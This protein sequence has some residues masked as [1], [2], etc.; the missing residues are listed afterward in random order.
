M[1]EN[2]VKVKNKAKITIVVLIAFLLLGAAS[3]TILFMLKGVGNPANGEVVI[4]YSE[5][6]KATDQATLQKLLAHESNM[7][8]EVTDDIMIN[9]P[10]TVKGGKKLTGDGTISMALYVKPYQYM[11][12]VDQDSKLELDG[13]TIDGNGSSN[14]VKV[15][16][17]AQCSLLS[18][19]LTYGCPTVI[20]SFGD[21]YIK[22]GAIVDAIGTGVY[23]HSTGKVYMT[24]GSVRGCVDCG[25]E[26]A[27]DSYISVSEKAVIHDNM[28]YFI[29]SK[30]TCDITGGELR[31]A[32]SD[33]VYTSGV[34]N[35]KYE[36]K[37]KGDMLKWHDIKGCAFI[38][39]NGGELN[40]DNLHVTDV[41]NRI[42]ST[43]AGQNIAKFSNCL[44]ENTGGDAV[45]VRTEVHLTNVEIKNAGLSGIMLIQ[46]GKAHVENVTV[47]GTKKDGIQCGGGVVTGRNF[48]ANSVGR[49]GVNSYKL[50]DVAASV[51]LRDVTVNGAKSNGL[52]VETSTLTVMGAKLNDVTGDGARAQKAGKL[53]ITNIEIKN[54]KGRNIASYDEG[55]R[56]VVKNAKTVAGQRGIG[57]F[58]G[59]VTATKVSIDSPTEFGVSASKKSNVKITDVTIK[60]SAKTA[61]N[62][63]DATITIDKATIENP[64]ETA[65]LNA[66]YAGKITLKNADIK[67]AKDTKGNIDGVRAV[68][69]ATIILEKVDITNAPRHGVYADGKQAKIVAKNVTST[70]CKRGIQ[71]Y[72]GGQV[73]GETVTIKS[74]A[75]YGVTCGDAGSKFTL[76]NLT[77]MNSGT[78]A[79]NVY[80]GAIGTVTNGTLKKSGAEA[81]FVGNKAQL[82]LN[83]VN[84]SDTAK[85]GVLNSGATLTVKGGSMK[86]AGEN[87][88]FTYGEGQTTLTDFSVQDSKSQNIRVN[89]V[90]SKCVLD[91]VSTLGGE[92]GIQIY[93]G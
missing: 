33:M 65:G 14:C 91:N 12:V 56:V 2:N 13:V 64:K 93:S 67:F 26:G 54:A 22:G 9:Q 59:D 41:E 51:T 28:E 90:N 58:G 49:I 60:N 66:D 20:E 31:D 80:D 86:D 88:V 5:K 72:K 24:A 35:V 1:E 74:P 92:R 79:V 29:Y 89:D 23:V 16:K 40:V 36:G 85:S 10:M 8:I 27:V 73:E 53:N 38:V 55:S 19:K 76:K 50:H 3:A 75:E 61:V 57:A 83:N 15:E 82:T 48:T 42:V 63:N 68:S 84:V 46:T 17:N 78:I 87:G 11:F 30:G 39:G 81:G 18:G 25:I 7:I 45:Y 37:K 43:A 62:A 4:K 52:H 47:S 77:V 44:F 71:I 69:P 21:V 32:Q 6:E 34:M 70:D